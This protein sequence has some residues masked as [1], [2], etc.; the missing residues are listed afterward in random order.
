MD[1]SFGQV[2]NI[3]CWLLFQLNFKPFYWEYSHRKQFIYGTIF[4][5]WALQLLLD[6]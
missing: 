5:P 1:F 4:F 3:Q 6:L 2:N